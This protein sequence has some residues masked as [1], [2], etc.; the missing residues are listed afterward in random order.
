[1]PQYGPATFKMCAKTIN[2]LEY[3]KSFVANMLG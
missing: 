2:I 1:M 3:L